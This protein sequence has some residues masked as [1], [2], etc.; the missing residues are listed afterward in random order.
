[1]DL[2]GESIRGQYL[3]LANKKPVPLI[4]KNIFKGKRH[5]I[6]R[7]FSTSFSTFR[8]GGRLRI[9]YAKAQS[10]APSGQVGGRGHVGRPVSSGHPA[11][12]TVFR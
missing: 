5:I 1:M 2:N 7:F 6:I 12:F 8:I 9:E 10:Q 3:T 4:G 11:V